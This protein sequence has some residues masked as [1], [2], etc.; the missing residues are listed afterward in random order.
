VQTERWTKTTALPPML[1][2]SVTKFS[3]FE[4]RT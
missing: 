2:H 3:K 1:M 4:M